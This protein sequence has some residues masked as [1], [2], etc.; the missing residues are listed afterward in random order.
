MKTKLFPFFYF[1][2]YLTCTAQE[3]K[4]D[5]SSAARW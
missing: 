2:I 3:G 1:S 4:F 5:V